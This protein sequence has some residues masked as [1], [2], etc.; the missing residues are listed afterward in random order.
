MGFVIEHRPYPPDIARGEGD[1]RTL[2][3]IYGDRVGLTAL[4]DLIDRALEEGEAFVS[5][6]I[7]NTINVGAC[8]AVVREDGW[9]EH[10]RTD[11]L[12]VA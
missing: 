2:T 7:P 8:C 10:R 11:H 1:P 9:Q 5:D 6:R 3:E 4:R 12:E